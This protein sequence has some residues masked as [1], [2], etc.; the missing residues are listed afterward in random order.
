[1]SLI[2]GLPWKHSLNFL[3]NYINMSFLIILLI[4]IN[5]LYNP[6][7]TDWMLLSSD[8]VVRILDIYFPP[9]VMSNISL[10]Q[11]IYWGNTIINYYETMDAIIFLSTVL[12]MFYQ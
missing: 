7:P 2:Y 4:S 8:K 11:Y 6:A 3:Y 1:M 10:P 5:V 12:L 9:E